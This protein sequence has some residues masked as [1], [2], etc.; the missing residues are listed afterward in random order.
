MREDGAVVL[1]NNVRCEPNTSPRRAAPMPVFHAPT[2]CASHSERGDRALARLAEQVN[3]LRARPVSGEDFEAMERELRTLFA[4]AEREVV[5]ETLER[6]DVDLPYRRD[7]GAAL[8]PG[9]AQPRDVHECGGHGGSAS[10]AVPARSG[11]C[12]GADGVA[13]G[14]SGR[15]L[16]GA[17]GTP[18]ECGGG[19]R[20]AAGGG[21]GVWGVGGDEAVEELAGSVAEGPGCAVGGG[22]ARRSRRRCA[23][24]AKCRRRR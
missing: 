1:W 9:A 12:G 7:G 24:G 16:D 3:A 20:D 23:R 6:L 14:E 8:P 22:G 17:G 18:G 4:E 19:A 10:H 13:G 11:A 2:H 15:S 21:E 5:G